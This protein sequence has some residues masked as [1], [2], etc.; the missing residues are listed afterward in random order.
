MAKTEILVKHEFGRSRT[1]TETMQ[2][3]EFWQEQ[4]L[5]QEQVFD[6]SRSKTRADVWERA[7]V[8]AIVGVWQEQEKDESKR[9]PFKIIYLTGQA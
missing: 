1:R 6:K 3:H 5:W 2:E 9:G 4:K 8:W 7:G